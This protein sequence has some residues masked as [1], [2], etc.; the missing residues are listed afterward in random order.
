MGIW[1]NI[2][3]FIDGIV[4]GPTEEQKR[5]M[6][7][8]EENPGVIFENDEGAP[9][10]KPADNAEHEY[11]L[12]GAQQLGIPVEQSPVRQTHA[13]ANASPNPSLRRMFAFNDGGGLPKDPRDAYK[14][15]IDRTPRN[16]DPARRGGTGPNTLDIPG[17][18]YETVI[19]A[20]PQ[21]PEPATRGG[22]GPDTLASY[23]YERKPSKTETLMQDIR[24][25]SAMPAEQHTSRKKRS[26]LQ[27]FG[28]GLW[29]GY[30]NWD[31]NKTGWSGGIDAL[32]GGLEEGF[33]PKVHAEGRKERKVGKIWNDL[34]Q[35]TQLQSVQ[36][37]QAQEQIKT[38][39]DQ[40]ELTQKRMKPYMDAALRKGYLTDDEVAYIKANG[41][42]IT[43]PNN[44]E[45]VEKGV[46]GQWYIRRKNEPGYVPNVTLPHEQG[47]TRSDT[48]ITTGGKD[49]TLPLTPK[50]AADVLIGAAD[51]AEK[52]RQYVQK[53]N[54]ELEDREYKDTKEFQGTVREWSAAMAKARG[55][56]AKAQAALPKLRSSRAELAAQ[57]FD[58]TQIDRQIAEFE[59]DIAEGQELLKQKKPERI[60][61]KKGGKRSYSQADIDRVIGGK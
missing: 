43:N 54:D 61:R 30:K 22:Y 35:E 1:N 60:Q 2:G 46:N 10:S 44:P 34:A 20:N 13:I 33:D 5:K 45:F 49:V 26:F 42:D 32:V 24:D 50:E 18:G 9:W 57:Q 23:D 12:A 14:P 7:W 29:R 52:A 6:K 8:E 4:N 11:W 16:P 38:L 47:E 36:Q 19:D 3:S 17:L 58:T 51:R 37:K 28:G 56:I 40:T 25:Q 15:V 39:T 48:T 27:R 41:V 53:R 31:P 21:N 55:Q 59:G